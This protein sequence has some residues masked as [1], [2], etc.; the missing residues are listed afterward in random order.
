VAWLTAIRG[1]LAAI[2]AWLARA[3]ARVASRWY[4]DG[5]TAQI[6]RAVAVGRRTDLPPRLH[7]SRLY[8]VGTPVKW[9][10]FR[11]PC[12][13][14]HQIDLNLTH[15]GRPRWTITLDPQH[16]PSL[17]PSVDVRADRRCHFWLTAGEV[18]W[19]QDSGR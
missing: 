4:L 16:R 14:G 12:G 7:P 15:G 11:C 18:R 17:R 3:A 6:P 9:A 5:P 19:C 2:R 13:T 8:L 1:W 10:V